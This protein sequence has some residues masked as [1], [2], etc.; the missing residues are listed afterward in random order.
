TPLET[1]DTDG[2]DDG[3]F[4]FDLTAKNEEILQGLPAGL[5][6]QYFT[7]TLNAFTFTNAI[8]NP[9]SFTNTTS[10]NQTVYARI[11]NGSECYGIAELELVVHAFGQSILDEQV[12]ICK[13]E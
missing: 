7:S 8:A 6:L 5:Q 10:G 12:I 13:N 3:F 9:A 4:V 1:C 2:T 11:Y